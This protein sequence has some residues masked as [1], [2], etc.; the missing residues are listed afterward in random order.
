[1]RAE[2]FGSIERDQ[3]ASAEALERLHAASLPQ[4]RNHLI[5][6]GLQMR[7]M[8]GIEHRADVIVGRNIRHAEQSVT[9]GGL[10]SFLQR[11]LVGKKRL[12]LHEKQRKRRQANVGHRIHDILALPLVGKGAASVAQAANQ[13]VEKLHGNGESENP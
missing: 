4:Y 12:R 9:V 11:T 1:L 7:G 8:D 3:R 10:A 6:R 2:I 13:V 5:K